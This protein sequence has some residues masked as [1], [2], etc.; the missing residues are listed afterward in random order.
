MV[1]RLIRSVTNKWGCLIF[2]S[3]TILL[4]NIFKNGIQSIWSVDSALLCLPFFYF[5][6]IINHK[7]LY[8][9]GNKWLYLMLLILLLSFNVWYCKSSDQMIDAA[10]FRFGNSIIL[11]YLFNSSINLC[12]FCVFANFISIRIP[13]FELLN[14][15]MILL[16]ACHAFICRILMKIIFTQTD[17]LPLWAAICT[18][19]LS[20][21]VMYP[22]IFIVK[23]HASFVLGK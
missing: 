12:L 23:K 6:E 5:G 14:E 10:S 11:Y 22:I 7:N 18:A 21:A 4:S 16:L 1:I 8:K 2:L 9:H 15:G 3:F 13:V 17:M 19:I 20:M